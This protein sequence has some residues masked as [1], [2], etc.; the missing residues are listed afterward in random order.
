MTAQRIYLS[1]TIPYVNAR[2]HVGHALELV[3]A[4]VLARHHRRIGDE[5]RLQSGTDDNSLKN[6][7]AAD[8]EG[9]S[10]RELVNRNASAFAGLREYLSLSFDDFI[11]TSSDPR[12]RPG[13]E[14]LWQ[15]C[16][17]SGDLYRRT[18]EGLYCVGCE[19]FYP[20]DELAGGKCPDHGTPVQQVAEENWFFR[21]S[22]YAGQLHELISS[23]QLRIE[24]ASRR[25]EVLAFIAG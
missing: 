15:A 1:T 23:G 16:Q 9:I 24:P 10:T 20:Q 11:R 17:A 25:N 21:L 18:C 3:Q 6:V 8:A 2:A 12:H 14:R 22:R 5:V 19:Q 4:D 7:L 13:V